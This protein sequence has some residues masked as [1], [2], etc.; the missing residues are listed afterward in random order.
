MPVGWNP[1]KPSTKKRSEK[2]KKDYMTDEEYDRLTGPEI[3]TR[4]NKA[5]YESAV[6]SLFDTMDYFHLPGAGERKWERG[7]LEKV[8]IAKD[9]ENKKKELSKYTPEAIAAAEQRAEQRRMDANARLN[10]ISTNSDTSKLPT[11]N[12]DEFDMLRQDI[13]RNI[14]DREFEYRTIIGPTDD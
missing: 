2:K 14:A 3:Q 11:G 10:S 6:G 4:R 13:K 12:Y 8:A 9:R 5:W 1:F 7:L